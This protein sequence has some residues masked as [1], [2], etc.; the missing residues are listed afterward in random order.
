M[1]HRFNNNWIRLGYA[2]FSIA[3]L[4]FGVKYLNAEQNIITE[5]EMVIIIPSYNNAQWYKANLDSVLSQQYSNFKIIYIDDCSPDGTGTLVEEYLK[6]YDIDNRVTLIKNDKRQLAMAN[7]Y[8]A[9][10]SCNDNVIIVNLD[11]DDW[12]AHDAVLS[13]INKEY[14]NPDVWIAY[15]LT[16]LYPQGDV[17]DWIREIPQE[18]IQNN[19]YRDYPWAMGNPRT[20]YAW[21]FKRIKKEDFFY[22]GNFF[23]Y[24][25]DQAMMHP[26]LEMAGGRTKFIPEVLY[27]YNRLTPIND[28]KVNR[29]LQLFF[30][31]YIRSKKRYTCLEPLIIYN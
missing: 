7:L 20:F 11:G 25:Y 8:Y 3:T 12:F 29:D 15:G 13:T 10:H 17:W 30:D 26:M 4:V 16:K 21:L 1:I 6:T 22:E 27:I 14:L 5:K 2:I 18:I 23:Q 9:I 28:D 24:T 19:A 31:H